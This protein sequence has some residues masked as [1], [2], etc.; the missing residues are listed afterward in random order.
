MISLFQSVPLLRFWI[1]PLAIVLILGSLVWIW[2]VV[3]RPLTSKA[4]I[5]A[6]GFGLIA[7][8]I[9]HVLVE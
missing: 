3:M 9:V 5:L 7:V 2:L 4:R 8:V 1:P 6:L